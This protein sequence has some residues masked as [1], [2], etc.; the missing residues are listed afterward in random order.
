MN[1]R[2]LASLLLSV[3]A[4]A[5]VAHAD[6][7]PTYRTGTENRIVAQTI[8]DSLL[9]EYP[10]LVT[11]GIHAVP[12]GGDHSVIVA[13]TLSVIGKKSD[14]EDVDV[15]AKGFTQLVPNAKLGKFGV[16]LPLLDRDGHR[17][18]ALGLALKYRDGDDQVRLFARATEIRNALAQRITGASELFQPTS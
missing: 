8:V 13:S 14:P 4:V 6:E 9:R 10:E 17:I 16:M 1:F 12:P 18:G 5:G 7:K 15:A 11:A 3:V 2:L